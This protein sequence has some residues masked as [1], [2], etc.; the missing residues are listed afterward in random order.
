MKRSWNCGVNRQGSWSGY[1]DDQCTS[2]MG[3]V[4]YDGALDCNN[5]SRII[6]FND[7]QSYIEPVSNIAMCIFDSDA[8]TSLP[9]DVP[10][11]NPSNSPTMMPSNSPTMNPSISPTTNPSNNPTESPVNDPEDANG[12]HYMSKGL[13]GQIQINCK[14]P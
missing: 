3:T 13:G 14:M 10:S 1:N 7:S 9:T 2:E 12:A 11:S 4:I 5:E 8:P 6:E